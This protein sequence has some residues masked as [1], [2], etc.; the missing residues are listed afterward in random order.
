[1]DNLKSLSHTVWDCKYLDQVSRLPISLPPEVL[2][3]IL[4]KNL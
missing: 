3:M 2:E 4:R 1:M